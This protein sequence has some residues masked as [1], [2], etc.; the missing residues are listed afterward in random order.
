VKHTRE[1]VA[2]DLRARL[3]EIFAQR[4]SDPRLRDLTVSDVRPSADLSFAKVFWCTRGA[5]GE[6]AAALESAKPF[7]RRCLAEVL[8]LRRVPELAFVRDDTLET[9]GRIDRILRELEPP[10][11]ASGTEEPA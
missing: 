2:H 9:A 11:P 6:V 8:K 1:R 4:V 7:V 3:A 10:A 5:A